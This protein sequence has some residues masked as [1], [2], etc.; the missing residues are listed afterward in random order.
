MTSSNIKQVHDHS[1][2]Q[3][4]IAPCSL[5][6]H[7]QLDIASQKLTEQDQKLNKFPSLLS[8]SRIRYHAIPLPSPL[9]SI[10]DH[11]NPLELPY[12]NPSPSHRMPNALT[13]LCSKTR[14]PMAGDPDTRDLSVGMHHTC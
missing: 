11:H 9:S 3:H 10:T 13:T 7:C 6:R 14:E 12:V 8:L 2:D 5:T 4:W 1:K